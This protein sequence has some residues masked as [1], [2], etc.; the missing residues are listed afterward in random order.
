MSL[1]GETS[2][3]DRFRSR[4][5]EVSTSL[6]ARCFDAEAGLL[7]D[8]PDL[9]E[10]S[11]HSQ[12]W[13]VLGDVV[14]GDAAR[15]LVERM[16]RHEGMHRCTVATSYDLF[17]AC[18]KV[19]R[20]DLTQD[21]WQAWYD[22]LEEGLTTWAEDP[23]MKRSDCHAWGSLPLFEFP[24]AYLGVRPGGDG[25]SS[26]VIEPLA[27]SLGSASGR[28]ATPH[29]PVVV[30]WSISEGG[31]LRIAGEAPQEIP[32]VLRHRGV[33]RRWDAGGEFDWEF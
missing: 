28:A 3:R 11:E 17:R 26:I 19:G 5:D 15:D 4:A 31:G 7:R 14:T 25:W 2:Q 20:Y 27:L 12:V 29:G 33:E 30:R 32:L 18:E 9:T 6:V 1:A 24:H 22:M 10:F 23:E 13:A 16:I 8:G 21:R